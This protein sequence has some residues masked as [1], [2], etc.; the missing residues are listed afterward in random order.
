LP[1]AAVLLERTLRGDA[2]EMLGSPAGRI[3]LVLLGWASAHHL[4]AG[5]RHLLMDV[6]IG[7]DLGAS[8]KSAVAAIIAALA[9]AAA[10]ASLALPS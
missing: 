1:F 7:A 2:V 3:A 9:V 10:A 5:V 8:R 6:G 4:F